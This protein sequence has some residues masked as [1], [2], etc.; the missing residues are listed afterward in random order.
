MDLK[1]K[2]IL[3]TGGT[4]FLGSH[5]TR[6]MQKTGA[7]ISS[8]GSREFGDLRSK[9]KCHELF[10]WQQPQIV[11]RLAGNVG[12]IGFNRDKPSTL[13]YDNIMMG[14]NLIEAA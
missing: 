10:V 7:N 12:G 2:K 13:F 3:I 9:N 14:V 8:A 6:E 11:I 5:V 4:G 1:N